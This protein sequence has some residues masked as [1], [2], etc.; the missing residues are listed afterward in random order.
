M[1]IHG[2]W[3]GFKIPTDESYEGFS[4]TAHFEDGSVM[5][6]VFDAEN[7]VKF[8]NPTGKACTGIDYGTGDS[9]DGISILDNILS[10]TQG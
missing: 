2:N 7:A 8:L 10:K 4:C 1:V 3:I 5:Q 9:A 6:G